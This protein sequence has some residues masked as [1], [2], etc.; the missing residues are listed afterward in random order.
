MPSLLRVSRKMEAVVLGL[1]RKYGVDSDGFE[2][3]FRL[4][5]GGFDDLIIEFQNCRTVIVGHYFVQNG[6]LVP[7]P[8]VWFLRMR[9]GWWPTCQRGVLYVCEA[10]TPKHVHEMV[11]FADEWSEVLESRYLRGDAARLVLPERAA[12]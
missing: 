9:E 3:S 10:N 6:D 2:E 5:L 11:Q 4:C 7:D 8:E 1:A 12:T